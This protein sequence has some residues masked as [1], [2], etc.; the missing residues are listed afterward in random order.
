MSRPWLSEKDFNVSIKEVNKV[1]EKN[2]ETEVNDKYK[3]SDTFNLFI[4][5]KVA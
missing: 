5:D 3:N 1:L 2:L 4:K